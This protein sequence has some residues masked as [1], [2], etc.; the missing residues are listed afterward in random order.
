VKIA[1]RMIPAVARPSPCSLLRFSWLRATRPTTTPAGG[2]RNASTSDSTA[3]VL[4]GV[5]EYGG[6]YVPE[7]LVPALDELEREMDAAF[8]DSAFTQELDGW[9]RDG[10]AAYVESLCEWS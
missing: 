1:L 7:T 3:I 10:S 4:V 2:N 8:S 9:L 5:G 6:A